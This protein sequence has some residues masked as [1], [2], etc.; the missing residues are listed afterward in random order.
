MTGRIWACLLTVVSACYNPPEPD[1]GFVCGPGGACPMD[2]TCASDNVCHRNGASPTLSCGSGSTLSFDVASAMATDA[3]TLVVTFSAPPDPT[4]ATTLGLYSVA[5]LT[6]TGTPT[7]TGSA[8][9]I[10]TAPQARMTYTVSVA[11]VTRATDRKQLGV[12]TATFTGIP[13]FDVTAA[14]PRT[15]HS[16]DVTFD[17]APDASLATNAANYTIASLTVSAAALNGSTVTLTTSAQS[18]TSFTVAVANVKRASDEIGLTT[19]SAMFTGRAPFDVS[20]GAFVAGSTT[21]MTITFDAVPDMTSAQN[22][23]NYTATGLTFSAAVLAGST[24]T[25][26]TATQVL[27]SYTVNVATVTRAS[28][29]EP[30]STNSANVTTQCGDTVKNGDET[31]A[32]CGGAT[33][34]LRC[35]TNKMCTQNTDCANGTCNGA[36]TGTCN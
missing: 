25:L 9:T 5:G 10:T 15:A 16:V 2:Y 29:S 8:V 36:P 34:T 1:C 7:L 31:D 11:G 22:A 21:S 12:T 32:D 28:D 3:T 13:P 17:A 6:L 20:G 27:P 26:T 14:T 35:A 30:L 24:V 4:T 18:A 23:A 33:C 19:A